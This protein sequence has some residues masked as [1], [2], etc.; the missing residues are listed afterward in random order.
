MAYYDPLTD[1]PNRNQLSKWVQE[2][3][4][5]NIKNLS[6]LFLDVDRFKSIND[7][8]GHAVGDTV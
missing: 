8:F 3:K 4:D 2:H 7:N 5:A 1:L 6:V